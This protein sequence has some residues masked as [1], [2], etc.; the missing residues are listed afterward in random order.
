MDSLYSSNVLHVPAESVSRSGA[1]PHSAVCS[2]H[3][4]ANSITPMDVEAHRAQF[5]IYSALP[6]SVS[7]SAFR[8]GQDARLLAVWK[9]RA[10]AEVAAQRAW[11]S[12]NGGR[13]STSGTGSDAAHSTGGIVLPASNGSSARH[14]GSMQPALNDPA[15]P[16]ATSLPTGEDSAEA[17]ECE[18]AGKDQL[19]ATKLIQAVLYCAYIASGTKGALR[20][21]AVTLCGCI[22][23]SA[24]GCTC[25][26][27]VGIAVGSNQFVPADHDVL[28]ST[29]G[30]SHTS[31]AEQAQQTAPLPQSNAQHMQRDELNKQLAA[32]EALLLHLQQESSRQLQKLQSMETLLREEV[33]RKH[34]LVV[35]LKQ[36][37]PACFC[38]TLTNEPSCE[39][40]T[41]VT[42]LLGGR[43]YWSRQMKQ[44]SDGAAESMQNTA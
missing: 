27:Q 21:C 44:A 18:R 14:Q 42:E 26:G 39:T 6:D 3:E 30:R 2:P 16:A 37:R 22:W 4:R 38:H 31:Q 29:T 8:D 15:A 35:E 25:L 34:K 36:V 9:Q 23:H 11:A 40:A 17:M 41:R 1:G 13:R 10:Q 5:R 12:E 28:A 32:E 24:P 43:L 19:A 7:R 20:P 33:A